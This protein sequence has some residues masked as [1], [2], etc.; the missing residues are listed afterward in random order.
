MILRFPLKWTDLIVCS[1]S[2]DPTPESL[3][4][5]CYAAAE[6]VLHEYIASALQQHLEL[7]CTYDRGQKRSGSFQ[8]GSSRKRNQKRH[9]I[10]DNQRSFHT[11]G[12]VAKALYRPKESQQARVDNS[13]PSSGAILDAPSVR[14]NAIE[15]NEALIR[16]PEDVQR[17][18]KTL[19]KKIRDVMKEEFR[20]S[21]RTMDLEMYPPSL[22]SENSSLFYQSIL[23][24]RAEEITGDAHTKAWRYKFLAS[25]FGLFQGASK[26]PATLKEIKQTAQKGLA[27]PEEA[28]SLKQD[29][30]PINVSQRTIHKWRVATHMINMMANGLAK[31]WK[32]KA[33]FLY[34][35]LSS[36]KPLYL[37]YY[38]LTTPD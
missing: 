11:D 8:E 18:A 37:V 3:Q 12:Y 29:T 9:Q 7:E 19:T 24:K 15:S 33:D 28:V 20:G 17:A 25:C 16:V 6:C 30:T 4:T 10:D 34:Y 27:T 13:L 1:S 23:W 5:S 38:W 31:S 14:A 21:S 2:I 22:H 26:K 32:W 36:K 35:A